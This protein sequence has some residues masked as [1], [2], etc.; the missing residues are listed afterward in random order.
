[1]CHQIRWNIFRVAC[2]CVGMTNL[3]EKKTGLSANMLSITQQR[4]IGHLGTCPKLC[5]IGGL[6]CQVELC[7]IHVAKLPTPCHQGYSANFVNSTS[8]CGLPE[9]SPN[10]PKWTSLQLAHYLGWFCTLSVIIIIVISN[11]ALYQ[12]NEAIVLQSFVH[13]FG[14]AGVHF[15]K[16]VARSKK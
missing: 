1:M 10:C 14:M 11:S 13:I 2:M 12:K 6:F 4:K 7:Q 16:F 3:N 8:Y 5:N 15:S 9:C